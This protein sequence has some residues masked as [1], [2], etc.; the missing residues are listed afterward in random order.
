MSKTTKPGGKL[1]LRT[2]TPKQPRRQRADVNSQGQKTGE[3]CDCN[4]DSQ[5]P[6]VLGSLVQ[7][8]PIYRGRK[9]AEVAGHDQ[10]CVRRNHLSSRPRCGSLDAH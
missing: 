10:I 1:E 2:I 8:H 3:R 4:V 6:A 9:R 5:W 7:L